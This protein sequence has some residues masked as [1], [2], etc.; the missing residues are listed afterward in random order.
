MALKPNASTCWIREQTI[1]DLPSGLKLRLV[2]NMNGARLTIEG[3]GLPRGNR[4]ILFDAEGQVVRVG[5][6]LK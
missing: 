4:E 6:L 2:A 5:P 3:S 1:E